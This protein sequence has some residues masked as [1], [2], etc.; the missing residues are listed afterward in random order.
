MPQS[1]NIYE[2]LILLWIQNIVIVCDD[3]RPRPGLL[4]VPEPDDAGAPLAPLPLA[5]L[6]LAPRLA[7]Q[8]RLLP[9]PS[10]N[11]LPDR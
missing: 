10:A 2:E 8:T 5:P 9:G 7:L 4:P 6:P 3:L 1:C 11:T